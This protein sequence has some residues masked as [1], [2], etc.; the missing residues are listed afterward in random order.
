MLGV[1]SLEHQFSSTRPVNNSAINAA[2]N[3][4]FKKAKKGV[5]ESPFK[6]TRESA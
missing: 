2:E 6:N 4:G 5:P 3:M 1:I